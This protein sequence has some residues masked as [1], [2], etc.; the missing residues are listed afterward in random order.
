LFWTVITK[1]SR[2]KISFQATLKIKIENDVIRAVLIPHASPEH[3]IK[4]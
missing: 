3:K 2:Q 4:Q 1:N